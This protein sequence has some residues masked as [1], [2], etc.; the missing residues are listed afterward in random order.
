MRKITIWMCILS[1]CTFFTGC[2]TSNTSQEIKQLTPLPQENTT[3]VEDSEESALNP[4]YQAFL[5]NEIRVA[6][7]YV[8]GT[9]LTVMDDKDYETE[10]ENAEKKYAL[11]DVNMDEN[12]E[13]IFKIS[14]YASELMYILGICNQ[15]LICYDV[16]E[17]HTKSVSFGVYDYGL[18]WKCENYDA[19]SMIYYSYNE[20]GKPVE[21]RRFTEGDEADIAAH[22]GAEPEWVDWKL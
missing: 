3:E 17:T 9:Y 6:N 5:H 11:V 14:S 19:F 10:F 1:I 20:E 8:E 16:F 15:E 2:G 7:P 18:V 12:P 22:E 4:L 21:A 13:L